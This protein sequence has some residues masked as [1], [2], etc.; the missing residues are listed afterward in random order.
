[1]QTLSCKPKQAL[2]NKMEKKWREV[3]GEGELEGKW[4]GYGGVI[5]F[6]STASSQSV[7]CKVR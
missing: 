5:S 7:Y 3:N 4:T 6:G 1:M 2:C